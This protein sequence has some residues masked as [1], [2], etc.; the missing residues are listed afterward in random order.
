MNPGKLIWEV[1]KYIEQLKPF[2]LYPKS[3]VFVTWRGILQRLHHSFSQC[4]VLNTACSEFV[5]RETLVETL[6]TVIL[7]LTLS[8]IHPRALIDPWHI[9]HTEH[10]SG[11]NF[12]QSLIFRA[13]VL[14]AVVNSRVEYTMQSL[15]LHIKTIIYQF[16]LWTHMAPLTCK[17]TCKQC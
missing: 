8:V 11:Q 16:V 2:L 7:A 12:S 10:W 3:K 17:L 4:T 9:T 1:G 15:L 6:E 13:I 14:E 5:R